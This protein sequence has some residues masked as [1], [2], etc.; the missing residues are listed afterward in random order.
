[1]LSTS[2]SDF[3]KGAAC[4]IGF[5]LVKTIV[6]LFQY[7]SLASIEKK[8]TQPMSN[9]T[10]GD[11]SQIT[12]FG[13]DAPDSLIDYQDGV[14]DSSPYAIR[15]E[16]YL[17]LVNLP[18]VKVA[19]RGGSENTRSKI[20]FCNIQGQMIDDSQ[21][22]VDTIREHSMHEDGL[23][24]Q[25]EALAHVIRQMIWNSL[26]W[27]LVHNI[28]FTHPGRAYFTAMIRNKFPPVIS[29]M[30]TAMVLTKMTAN[31]IGSGFGL[32]PSSQIAK[33]GVQ[34]VTALDT[35]LGTNQYMLGTKHPTSLDVD[36]Y[37][38]LVMFFYQTPQLKQPWVADIKNQLPRLVEYVDRL[39]ALWFPELSP[40]GRRNET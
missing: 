6:H 8:A 1:M 17:R 4:V 2:S 27:V 18:Y 13:Y 35:L 15:V 9:R 5:V 33:I 25:Q 22:I 29:H 40:G 37:A 30:I 20:P 24:S 16:T 23:T 7:P 39:R 14:V 26:Y 11:N 34:N 36:C 21:R 32:L 38:I 10:L 19:S 3:F 28:F 31:S 12:V